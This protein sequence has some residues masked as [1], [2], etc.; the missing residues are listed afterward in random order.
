M[1]HLILYCRYSLPPSVILRYYEALEG[2]FRVTFDL[3]LWVFI[4][5][6]SNIVILWGSRGLFSCHIWPC[7]VDFI[8]TFSKNVLTASSNTTLNWTIWFKESETI[9][10]LQLWPQL[11]N[12]LICYWKF[13]LKIIHS[14][15]LLHVIGFS[16]LFLISHSLLDIG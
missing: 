8:T 12:I 6:F 2:C 1:S 16:F 3:V 5:T 14:N 4:T 9:V 13:L 11:L 7:I 15:V 10:Y